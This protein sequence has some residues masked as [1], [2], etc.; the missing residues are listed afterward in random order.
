MK[1]LDQGVMEREEGEGER[2]D[3]SAYIGII[4]DYNCFDLL[5]QLFV[6]EVFGGPF[7]N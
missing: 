4:E 6:E 7:R 1:G 2:S 3:T 5:L